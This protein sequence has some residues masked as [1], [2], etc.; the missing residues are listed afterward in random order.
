MVGKGGAFIQHAVFSM[1]P[2]LYEAVWV[3]RWTRLHHCPRRAHRLERQVDRRQIASLGQDVQVSA[4]CATW[5]WVLQG[6]EGNRLIDRWWPQE[7]LF[8]SRVCLQALHSLLWEFP[9]WH[10]GMGS[11]SAAPGCRF[12]P[13]PAQWVRDLAL[14]QLWCRLLAAWIRCLAQEVHK[15]RG[16]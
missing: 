6:L 10:N 7:G 9:L 1:N 8:W 15:L 13:W 14:Q 5:L 3:Q 16:G 11:V 12:D 2:M 4:V